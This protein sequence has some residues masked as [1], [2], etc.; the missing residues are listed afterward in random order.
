M[1]R[2][3]VIFGV[4]VVGILA[5]LLLVIGSAWIGFTV[6]NSCEQARRIVQ[7]D[8][9]VNALSTVVVDETQSYRVRNDAV[10]ALGQLGDERALPALETLYTGEIPD[11]EPLDETLSQYEL[12][13]AIAL[14]KGGWNGSVIFRMWKLGR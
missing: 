9:C 6:E 13:K 3:N 14:L 12:K 5:L 7:S 2:N 8:D 1:N 4:G 10:W 11:R